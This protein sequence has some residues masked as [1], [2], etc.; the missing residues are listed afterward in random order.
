MLDALLAKTML[1]RWVLDGGVAMVGLV[2]LSMYMVGLLLNGLLS[3]RRSKCFTHDQ[4]SHYVA[5]ARKGD[6]DGLQRTLGMDSSTMLSRIVGRALN[7]G[8][9][10]ADI[11]ERQPDIVAESQEVDVIRDEVARSMRRFTPLLTISSVA[12]LFGILGTVLGLM[13][14]FDAHSVRTNPQASDLA[15]GMNQALI[16]MIW[17][18]CIA[19]PATM[20]HAFLRSKHIVWEEDL[21]PPVVGSILIH[22]RDA[23]KREEMDEA[24]RMSRFAKS[25]I[26]SS[27]SVSGIPS[28]DWSPRKAGLPTPSPEG[29]DGRPTAVPAGQR[30][31]SHAIPGDQPLAATD[32]TGMIDR[33]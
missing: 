30:H 12:P 4:R 2:P 15:R 16:T 27:L 20:A 13:A 8:R 25:D 26:S 29:F 9:E 14:A 32:I 3:L 24:R 22:L 33:E 11:P 28:S 7:G 31:V 5:L 21:L 6:R 18:L 17:G 10:L 1:E 19:I 23:A